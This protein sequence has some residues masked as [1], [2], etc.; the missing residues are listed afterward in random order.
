MGEKWPLKH[1]GQCKRKTRVA[2]GMEQ[3][4]PA[5]QERHVG[6][7]SPCSHGADLP[8]QPWRNIWCDGEQGQEE[9]Q[10]G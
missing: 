9:Q 7:L 1:R 4:P 3:N 2:P 5:L 8:V 6:G 10:E